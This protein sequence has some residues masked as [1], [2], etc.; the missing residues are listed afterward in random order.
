M[1]NLFLNKLSSSSFLA[2]F[3]LNLMPFFVLDDRYAFS[4]T[5]CFESFALVCISQKKRS[6][7]RMRFRPTIDCVYK[8]TGYIHKRL[9]IQY[10]TTVPA[11][12]RFVRTF[13]LLS[14][15]LHILQILKNTPKFR[16]VCHSK[17]FIRVF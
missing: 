16:E 9:E 4:N 10:C 15:I 1:L 11:N 6:S 8:C 13:I 14:G 2:I 3:Q 5:W 7:A 17:I 12:F